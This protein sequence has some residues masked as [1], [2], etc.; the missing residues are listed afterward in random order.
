MSK[1]IMRTAAPACNQINRAMDRPCPE[2]TQYVQ[3]PKVTGGKV[4]HAEYKIGTLSSHR[5]KEEMKPHL[6]SYTGVIYLT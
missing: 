4:T 1:H 2:L 5:D 3:T 6:E